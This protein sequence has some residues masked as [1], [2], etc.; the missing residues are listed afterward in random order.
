ME[1]EKGGKNK[2]SNKCLQ[3]ENVLIFLWDWNYIKIL[4]EGNLLLG[5]H[6]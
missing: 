5:D 3:M 2:Y 4:K 1:I 6:K